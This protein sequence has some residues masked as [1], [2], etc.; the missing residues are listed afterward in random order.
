MPK[1]RVHLSLSKPHHRLLLAFARSSGISI[2]EAL[3]RILDS[4]MV[5]LTATEAQLEASRK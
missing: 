1:D 4:Y 2:S 3:G 5:A